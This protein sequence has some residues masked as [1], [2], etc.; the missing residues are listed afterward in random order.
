MP[1]SERRFWPQPQEDVHRLGEVKRIKVGEHKVLAL[2]LYETSVA[3]GDEP[4]ELPVLRGRV[5]GSMDAIRCTA[6]GKV[7]DWIIGED[8]MVRLIELIYNKT[9]RRS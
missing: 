8:A 6:C 1:A 4:A 9:E 2:M 5:I 7:H 3:C